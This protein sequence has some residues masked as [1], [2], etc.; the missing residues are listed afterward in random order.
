LKRKRASS[1]QS[2]GMPNRTFGQKEALPAWPE[3]RLPET[4]CLCNR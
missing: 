4:T 2:S 3:G 1:E